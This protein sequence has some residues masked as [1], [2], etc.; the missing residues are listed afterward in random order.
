MADPFGVGARAGIH[1]LADLEAGKAPREDLGPPIGTGLQTLD[2]ILGGADGGLRAGEL[3]VVGARSGHGKSAL[4]EQ[5]AL[6]TS[7]RHR[8][9]YFA[10]ELG[11][12]RTT[13]RLLAKALRTDE[14]S[15][16]MALKA[17]AQHAKAA[18][19]SLAYERSLIVEERDLDT[20][21]RLDDALAIMLQNQPK[22]VVLDHLRHF[23][24]WLV[25]PPGAD[26]P[27]GARADYAPILF[28]RRLHQ[29]A[30]T[31]KCA[32]IAVHQCKNQLQ[33]KRPTQHDLADT[34]A[35]AQVADHVWMIHRPF[36]GE[37]HRDTIAEVVVDKNRRGPECLLH[38]EWTGRLMRYR[39]LTPDD[40]MPCCVKRQK[41]GVTR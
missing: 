8:T 19:E 36:R 9:T 5:I 2:W 29:A 1:E 39:D 22:V 40:E 35:L 10:L 23:D 11:R 32:I 7:L 28:S 25:P 31:F 3:V 34:A 30:R 12:E 27:K 33:A 37:V 20:D 13:D 16:R 38:F 21:F 26:V 6:A 4:A 14:Q 15:A 17:G 18:L 24:D 41:Y